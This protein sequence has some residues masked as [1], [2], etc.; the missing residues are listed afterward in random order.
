VIS[1]FIFILLLQVHVSEKFHV[2]V[3]NSSKQLEGKT[4]IILLFVASH[5]LTIL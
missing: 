3:N 5:C 1:S 4:N 2:T